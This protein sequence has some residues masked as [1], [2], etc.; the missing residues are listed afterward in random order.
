MNFNDLYSIE[1]IIAFLMNGSKI[2]LHSF[3]EYN[4]SIIFNI[5]FTEKEKLIGYDYQLSLKPGP[6]SKNFY[7]Q[8]IHYIHFKVEKYFSLAMNILYQL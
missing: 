6:V 1:T 2:V 3:V 7:F 5:N 4:N 8:N